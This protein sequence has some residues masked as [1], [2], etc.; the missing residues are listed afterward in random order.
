MLM[1]DR[2]IVRAVSHPRAIGQRK[3]FGLRGRRVSFATEAKLA[4]DLLT[5]EKPSRLWGV[6]STA[7]LPG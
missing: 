6:I 3:R 2:V 1:I 5:G 4:S 7:E